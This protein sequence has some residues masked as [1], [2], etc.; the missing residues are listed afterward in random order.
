MGIFGAVDPEYADIAA[1][2]RACNLAERCWKDGE[3]AAAAPSSS[4]GA[5][6]AAAVPAVGATGAGVTMTAT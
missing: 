3:G 6:A 4:G 2:P 1:L 5:A